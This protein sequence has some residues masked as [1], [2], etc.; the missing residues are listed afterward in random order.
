MLSLCEIS[1]ALEK[2]LDKKMRKIKKAEKEAGGITE[3]VEV[4]SMSIMPEPARLRDLLLLLWQCVA[5]LLS[6]SS[7]LPFQHCQ[8]TMSSVARL[9]PQFVLA[10]PSRCLSAVPH[11]P[12]QNTRIDHR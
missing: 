1:Q 2:L 4:C 9:L 10:A 6:L 3:E 5:I 7:R 11:L 12:T 8:Q